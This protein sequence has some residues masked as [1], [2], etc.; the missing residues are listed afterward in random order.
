MNSRELQLRTKRF[1][2]AIIP[3]V[4]H[5]PKDRVGWTFTDQSHKLSIYNRKLEGY[6]NR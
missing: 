5:F 1:A 6:A 3:L 4:R 2:L